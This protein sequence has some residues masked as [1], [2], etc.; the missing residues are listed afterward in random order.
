M[1]LR[2]GTRSSRLSLAQTDSVLERLRQGFPDLTIERKAITHR[3]NDRRTALVSLNRTQGFQQEVVQAVLD[4]RVDF[5]V[6]GIKNVPVFE[7]NLELF[8]ASVLERGS[9]A[10]V[11]VSGGSRRL[12]EL[13]SG[14]V[15]GANTPLRAVQV[16]RARPDLKP[17]QARGGVTAQVREVD[18]GELD[19]AILA[20]SGLARLAMTGKIAER[21]SL[22]EFIPPPGQGVLV[23]VARR[24]NRRVIEMLRK[25]EHP[26]TRAEAEAERELVRALGAGYKAP[27]GALASTS[28]DR[29]QLM[30]QILSADGKERLRAVGTAPVR[31]ALSLARSVAEN[32]TV[33]GAARIEEGWRRTLR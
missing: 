28:G 14:S 2:A 11:L 27:I 1:L 25:V 19:A 13:K 8:I 29:I 9:P 3:M 7:P 18:K 16:K 24:D 30:A 33:Q 32:L 31:D 26:P 10:N 17:K 20:E 15:I 12:K 23:A 4:G 22:E 6:F 5:A 21:L